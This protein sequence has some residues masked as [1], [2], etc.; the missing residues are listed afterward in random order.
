[1]EINNLITKVINLNPHHSCHMS[2]DFLS[3]LLKA[4]LLTEV[5]I[6]ER[7]FDLYKFVLES[8]KM[9]VPILI[10]VE[11]YSGSHSFALLCDSTG[12]WNILQ[13]IIDL[14]P[15]T[16]TPISFDKVREICASL[17]E[18]EFSKNKDLYQK[19]FFAKPPFSLD[20]PTTFS[21]LHVKVFK[22]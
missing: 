11:L 18:I 8:L 7:D 3:I 20:L 10:H 21:L 5:K 15:L 14:Y 6:Q 4:E 12:T 17:M 13:S 16:I 9:P 1:M 22:Y 19:L 2:I